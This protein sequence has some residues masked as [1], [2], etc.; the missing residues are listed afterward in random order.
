MAPLR[1][2]RGA[3]EAELAALA[4]PDKIVA[5]HPAVIER[6]LAAVAE[7]AATLRDRAVEGH[8]DVAG[9]LREL[10]AAVTVAPGAGNEPEL[11][12]SGRLAALAGGELFPSGPLHRSAMV[13][14]EG[15]EPPTSGL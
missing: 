9:A 5:L 8:E 3:L 2:R 6:Y 15:F 1:A 10:V 7:L 14:G 12:V 11:T 4:P 13:A